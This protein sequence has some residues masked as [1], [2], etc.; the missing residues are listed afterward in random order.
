MGVGWGVGGVQNFFLLTKFS[1]S[2]Y[3][4]EV[5]GNSRFCEGTF[6]PTGLRPK[7]YALF[8]SVTAELGTTEWTALPPDV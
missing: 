7:G 4:A 6:N 5:R 3:D 2:K 1:L 8:R